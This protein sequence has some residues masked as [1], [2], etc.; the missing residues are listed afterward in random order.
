MEVE[1][2][3]LHDKFPSSETHVDD[4][5]THEREPALLVH[6]ASN[7]NLSSIPANVVDPRSGSTFVSRLKLIGVVA[8][9]RK[10]LLM[11]CFMFAQGF[12]LSFTFTIIPSYIPEAWGKSAKSLLISKVFLGN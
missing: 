3:Q 10:T 1:E 6:L 2:T 4:S 12:N 9:Q 11:V 5:G 7:D 8:T